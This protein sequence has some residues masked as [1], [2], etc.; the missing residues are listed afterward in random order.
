MTGRY[1]YGDGEEL[2]GQRLAGRGAA[3]E[4]QGEDQEAREIHLTGQAPAE[5]ADQDAD[6]DAE[7]MR[8]VHDEEEPS[9]GREPSGAV[10]AGQG[11]PA[12]RGCAGSPGPLAV[13]LHRCGGGAARAGGGRAHPGDH[14]AGRQAA[15][16]GAAAG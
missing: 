11:W 12:G 7:R 6:P 9:G 4:R 8:Q 14:P 1:G 3:T 15:G 13:H 10:R 2:R 16:G 5:D